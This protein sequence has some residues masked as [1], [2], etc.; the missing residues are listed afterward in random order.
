MK[1]GGE[2]GP[3]SV[4]NKNQLLVSYFFTLYKDPTF[5]K[6]NV[7]TPVLH[8]TGNLVSMLMQF[9]SYWSKYCNPKVSSFALVF[10]QGKT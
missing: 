7:P 6:E 10:S 4:G 9:P 5:R 8:V 2:T 1:P 3:D